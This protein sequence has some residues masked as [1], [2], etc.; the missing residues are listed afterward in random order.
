MRTTCG[1]N[2]QKRACDLQLP[3]LLLLKTSSERFWDLESRNDTSYVVCIHV[4]FYC[5]RL[6]AASATA[7]DNVKR[8]I[9]GYGKPYMLCV[10]MYYC[11]VC[12]SDTALDNVKWNFVGFGKQERWLLLCVYMYFFVCDL[13]LPQPL[14]LIMWSEILCDY[15]RKNA[16]MSTINRFKIMMTRVNRYNYNNVWVNRYNYESTVTIITTCESTVTV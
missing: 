3:Q 5:L 2:S 12:D 10:Y 14:L 6:A 1:D 15:Y 16:W 7:L 13:Q 11:I 9:L 4:L 8:K